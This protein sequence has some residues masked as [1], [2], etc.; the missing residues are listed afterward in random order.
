VYFC[1]V[2]GDGNAASFINS[3]YDGFGTGIAPT[4]CGFTLQ[5]RGHNF[6]LQEGHVNCVGPSKRPYH[7][8]IPGM[9][10]RAGSGELFA[11]FGVMGGFMQ[12]QG[13]GETLLHFPAQRVHF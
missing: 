7:T 6:I 8:I 1:V 4:G 3:N 2:D 13:R 10:T 9:A 11:A 12:P 5:N